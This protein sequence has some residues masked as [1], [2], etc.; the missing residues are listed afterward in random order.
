MSH[1]ILELPG[2]VCPFS[3]D[4]E[5]PTGFQLAADVLGYADDPEHGLAIVGHPSFSDGWEAGVENRLDVSTMPTGQDNDENNGVT[6]TN[7]R[8][9]WLAG[10]IA[11]QYAYKCGYPSPF[12]TE[13]SHGSECESAPENAPY[14]A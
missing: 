14:K 3:R 10:F 11:G 7:A 8:Q 13:P 12:C 2:D 5:L 4:K 9:A 6:G 1:D